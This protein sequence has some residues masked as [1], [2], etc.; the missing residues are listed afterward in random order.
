MILLNSPKQ[1]W[2]W[3]LHVHVARTGGFLKTLLMPLTSTHQGHTLYTMIT[4][5]APFK[6]ETMTQ[7]MIAA[8]RAPQT[9]DGNHARLS[10]S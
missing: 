8:E 2:S 9:A 7:I 4:G 5:V 6:K 3:G 10:V 1:A